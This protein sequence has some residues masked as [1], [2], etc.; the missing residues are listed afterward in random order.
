MVESVGRLGLGDFRFADV[1][2]ELDRPGVIGIRKRNT[3]RNTI[4]PAPLGIG[5]NTGYITSQPQY[6]CDC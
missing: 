6:L 4:V 5:P 2:D 3:P 1:S